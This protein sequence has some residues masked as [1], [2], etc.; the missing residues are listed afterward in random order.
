MRERER[1][2]KS[3]FSFSSTRAENNAI[4]R[5]KFLCGACSPPSGG[6][7]QSSNKGGEG[8]SARLGFH[9]R[10]SKIDQSDEIRIKSFVFFDA[11]CVICVLFLDLRAK[12]V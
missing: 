8:Q 12:S 4:S 2:L 1:E 7:I 3:E 11:Y 6:L 5:W 9:V 10:V